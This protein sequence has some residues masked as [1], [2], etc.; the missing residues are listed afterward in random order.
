MVDDLPEVLDLA[1]ELLHR[2][3]VVV[4]DGDRVLVV[5]AEV[6]LGLKVLQS[7]SWRTHL[8]QDLFWKQKMTG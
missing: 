4:V 7:I 2:P 6:G 5:V 8:E 3:V 1:E